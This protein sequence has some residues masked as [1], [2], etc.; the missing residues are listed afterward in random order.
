MANKDQKEA[1]RKKG[2]NAF[3][4]L[5]KKDWFKKSI[6]KLRKKYDLPS[7]DG[8]LAMSFSKPDDVSKSPNYSPETYT[9]EIRSI[10]EK[11]DLN[12]NEF[13][14]VIQMHIMTDQTIELE[15]YFK[16][17]IRGCFVEDVTESISFYDLTLEYEE[18][19]YPVILRISPYASARDIKTYIDDFYKEKIEPLQKKHLNPKNLTG[20]VRSKK[21]DIQ[22]RN[23]FIYNHRHMNRKEIEKLGNKNFSIFPD[24]GEIGKIISLEK[25]RRKV[26]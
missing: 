3:L 9:E 13:V 5:V 14:H 12:P 2:F 4:E 22:D 8:D 18:T 11:A 16:N 10:C 25:K 6:T 21:A 19:A 23:D 15:G 1:N 17:N 24:Q 7:K 20:K 26:V